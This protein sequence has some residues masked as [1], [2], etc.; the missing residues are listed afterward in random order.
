MGK[1]GVGMFRRQLFPVVRRPGLKDN[2]SPLRRAANIQ[3]T[4]DLEEITVVI[5]RMQFAGSKN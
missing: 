5:E 2:R 3:R 4:G 1:N